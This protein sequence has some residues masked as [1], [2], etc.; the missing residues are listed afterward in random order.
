[1]IPNTS[2]YTRILPGNGCDSNG[3]T[4]TDYIHPSVNVENAIVAAPTRT[5]TVTFD[6]SRSGVV[7]AD[8]PPTPNTQMRLNTVA[9]AEAGDAAAHSVT[10]RVQA[11]VIIGPKDANIN[12]GTMNSRSTKLKI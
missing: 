8:P 9:T 6:R 1:M 12:Y 11:D 2:N 3:T 4:V 7:I 10:L 5:G